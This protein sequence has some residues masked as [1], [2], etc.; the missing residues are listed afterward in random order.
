MFKL[1]LL[2]V[3]V[4]LR[5]KPGK[6]FLKLTSSVPCRLIGSPANMGVAN[7]IERCTKNET[8]LTVGDA[9]WTS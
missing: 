5:G 7:L 1:D 3:V 8:Y 2:A 6:S 9:E 4:R